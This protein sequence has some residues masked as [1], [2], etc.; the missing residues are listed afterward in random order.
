MIAGAVKRS[1][2]KR[3][4]RNETEKKADSVSVGEKTLSR[5]VN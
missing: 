5:V 1:G 3:H 2:G 4:V